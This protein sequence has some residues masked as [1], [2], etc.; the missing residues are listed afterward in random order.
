MG[1]DSAATVHHIDPV[2]DVDFIHRTKKLT[3]PDNLI[4]TSLRTHNTIHF[5]EREEEVWIG[6]KEGDTKLW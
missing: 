3:D 2:S 1:L 5:R 4:T 6:R